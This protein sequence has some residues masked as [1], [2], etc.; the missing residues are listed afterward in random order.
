MSDEACRADL[1][2]TSLMGE[3]GNSHASEEFKFWSN[4]FDG[5]RFLYHHLNAT[6]DVNKVKTVG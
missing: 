4:N 1:E 3:L 5:I 2:I 6:E